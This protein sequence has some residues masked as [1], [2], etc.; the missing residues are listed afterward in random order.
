MC[1]IAIKPAGADPLTHMT[2]LAN[3][4]RRNPDGGGMMFPDNGAIRC[5]KG[6]MTWPSMEK[7]IRDNAVELKVRQVAFHFRIATHGSIGPGNTHPFP[8]TRKQ[9]RLVRRNSYAQHAYMHNGMITGLAD[10]RTGDSD[11]LVFARDYLS[12][13]GDSVIGKPLRFILDSMSGLNKFAFMSAGR[14]MY[15]IGS[16]EEEDKWRFSNNSYKYAVVLPLVRTVV[17]PTAN[18]AWASRPGNKAVTQT[19]GLATPP[20]KAASLLPATT[21]KS[22]QMCSG[23]TYS[24]YLDICLGCDAEGWYSDSV[25]K[26]H[27]L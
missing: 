10:S 5:V 22:C 12:T 20:A 26:D 11:T 17:Y 27:M 7:Y 15:L 25:I 21:T 19:A 16:F 23:L 8:I 18:G 2:W 3:S 6:F 24:P 1:I 14:G 9:G 4:W 13:F